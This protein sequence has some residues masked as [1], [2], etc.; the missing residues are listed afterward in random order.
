MNITLKQAIYASKSSTK[1]AAETKDWKLR[2]KH[3]RFMKA[4][5]LKCKK[6]YIIATA[7]EMVERGYLKQPQ[8]FTRDFDFF[9]KKMIWAFWASTTSPYV[10]ISIVPMR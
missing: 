5:A 2:T 9:N 7:D 3:D 4:E 10:K 1:T 6:G 8:S